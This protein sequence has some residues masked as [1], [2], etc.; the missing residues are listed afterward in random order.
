MQLAVYRHHLRKRI[1]PGALVL[2]AGCGPGTFSKFLL[3]LGARVTCLDISPV[4]LEACRR[5]A[6]GAESYELGSITDLG[7]MP[8]AG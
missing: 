6:P 7:R 8:A 4:Q 5:A 2:D 1:R 3:E